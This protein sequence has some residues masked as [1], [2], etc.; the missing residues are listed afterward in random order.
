V[1]RP[2]SCDAKVDYDSTAAMLV[3]L[4]HIQGITVDWEGSKVLLQ[5]AP[6]A[7]DFLFA[8]CSV[9]ALHRLGSLHILGRAYP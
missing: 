7:V 9:L 1:K 2:R 3:V 6:L 5:H 8:L 4:F